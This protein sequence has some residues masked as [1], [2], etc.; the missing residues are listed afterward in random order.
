MDVY[1][2]S[3]TSVKGSFVIAFKFSDENYIAIPESV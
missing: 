3:R 2:E 1:E